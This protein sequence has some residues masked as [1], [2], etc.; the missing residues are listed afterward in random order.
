M[1]AACP[2]PSPRGSR[3]Q[4]VVAREFGWDQLAGRVEQVYA[5]VTKGA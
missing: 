2:F 3:A 4:D 5:C 1:V